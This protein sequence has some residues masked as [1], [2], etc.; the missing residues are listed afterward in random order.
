VRDR[1]ARNQESPLGIEVEE[2]TLPGIGL[3]RD[4]LTRRGRRV[5]VVSHRTGKR[6]LLVYGTEDPDSCSE[7]VRL[8]TDESDTLAELL[9][10]PRIVE[11]LAT[12][13][14]Q[15]PELQVEELS[16][17]PGS[18]FVGRTLGDTEARTR[19]G[20]S[21]VAVLRNDTMIASPN[22]DFRFE[23]GDVVV[24]VGTRDGIEGVTKILGG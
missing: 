5:G 8:D 16:I 12:M 10:A 11:K 22:P 14:Q 15:V 6:E 9:G 21:V 7:V 24:V 18:P 20:A 2:V 23:A 17:R 4:F 3:R 13:R 19:T 1:D